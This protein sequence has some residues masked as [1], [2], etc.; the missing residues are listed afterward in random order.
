MDSEHRKERRE[1][2][3]REVGRIRL[4]EALRAA[5]E[6]RADPETSRARRLRGSVDRSLSHI[7]ARAR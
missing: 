1:E 3:R 5:G 6:R 2:M 4:A 7:V